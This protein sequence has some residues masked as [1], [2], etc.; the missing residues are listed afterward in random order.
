M[1]IDFIELVKN[2]LD[3]YG[4]MYMN[5][6]I[7]LSFNTLLSYTSLEDGDITRIIDFMNKYFESSSGRFERIR[8]KEIL[9]KL[10]IFQRLD[11]YNLSIINLDIIEGHNLI[12]FQKLSESFLKNHY[13]WIE[14]NRY[15]IL[16]HQV[17]PEYLLPEDKISTYRE[18][19]YKI[20]PKENIS[21]FPKYLR[22]FKYVDNKLLG[23]KCGYDSGLLQKILSVESMK[24]VNDVSNYFPVLIDPLDIIVDTELMVSNYVTYIKFPSN[25]IKLRNDVGGL[26]RLLI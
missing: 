14:E 4:Y 16:I 8:I 19:N 21:I 18:L 25:I 2:L 23:F 13:S 26:W 6:T 12:M 10:I 20:S 3:K 11:Q 15:S 1:N 22:G 17:I 7:E 9:D 24:F 5:D